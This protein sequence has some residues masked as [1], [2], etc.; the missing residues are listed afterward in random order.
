MFSCLDLF[1]KNIS[2]LC[3]QIM[4]IDPKFIKNDPNTQKMLQ[5]LLESQP[6]VMF[7]ASKRDK[8]SNDVP[9]T[10]TKGVNKAGRKAQVG[11]CTPSP[12]PPRPPPLLFFTNRKYSH[13]PIPPHPRG[14]RIHYWSLFILLIGWITIQP[15]WNGKVYSCIL[16]CLFLG[17]TLVNKHVANRWICCGW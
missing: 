17:Y 7:E 13:T 12:P 5:E 15:D 8:K 1:W 2:N 3:T 14:G 9:K 11:K 6:K 4:K 10:C 16:R